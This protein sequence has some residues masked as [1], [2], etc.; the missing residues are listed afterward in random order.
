[1]SE[2]SLEKSEQQESS[3]EVERI[4]KNKLSSVRNDLQDNAYIQEAMRV[5]PVGGYRSAIG[6]IWNAVVDDLRNK[7]IHRSLNLFNKEME[8]SLSRQI[9][10]YD[11]FQNYVNDDQLIEGAYK[12]GVIGWEAQKVLKHAKETRHIFDGH[13]RSSD[14]TLIKVLGM[15]ED[16]VKYVLDVEYPIQIID[17]DD[18]L[19]TMESTNYD[20]NGV[21]IENSLSELPEIYKTE[22]VNRLF[23]TYIDSNCTTTMRS[24]IEF[25]APILWRV[26]PKE[27]KNTIAK[28]VDT[29]INKHNVQVTSFCFQ[30][31]ENVGAL[32]I[33]SVNARRYKIQ[34][35]ITR[36]K[37]NLDNWQT[38]NECVRE[39]SRYAEV[40]PSDLME[41]YVSGLTL[42][43]VGTIG[44]SYQYNRTDFYADGAAMHIPDMFEKFDDTAA[45][46][47]INTLRKNT[48]L[49]NRISNP[50]KLRRLRTLGQIIQ[51]RISQS[52]HDKKIIELLCDETQEE[53][54]LKDIQRKR[55]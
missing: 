29:E 26:L 4:L 47:F 42:T 53:K 9:K 46:Y 37:D 39:L 3:T 18:Y 22:L 49:K 50:Q 20:R 27:T 36:L 14:P 15:L 10:E 41:D 54:F 30:F 24:N 48:I 28:R 43:Y 5:L 16:C 33:L 13:P 35:T 6:S 32:R 12:I 1:M 31:V 19:K 52:F 25:M 11:D 7:I 2:Q 17:I 34:P 44:S 40:I 55:A 8:K 23:S 38:E 51:D 45:E 21:I